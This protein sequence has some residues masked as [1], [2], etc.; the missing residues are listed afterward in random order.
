MAPLKKVH[1][2]V[3]GRVT[4][5]GFRYFV[6]RVARGLKLAGWVRNLPDDRV[7][8]VAEGEEKALQAFVARLREGPPFA[9]VEDV[10]VEWGPASGDL[11]DFRIVAYR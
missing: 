6:E 3:S 9:R 1:V 8:S 2:L 5:V 11:D 4:G 7:E 10:S